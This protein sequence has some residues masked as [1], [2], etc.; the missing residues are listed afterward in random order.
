MVIGF[1]GTRRGMSEVQKEQVRDFLNTHSFTELHHGDCIGSDAEFHD[2]GLALVSNLY[3]H[4]PNSELH[5]RAYCNGPNCVIH[6]PKP[7]L[8]RNRA[9]VDAS[10]II[11]AAPYFDHE[12]VRSGV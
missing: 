11:I 4:P 3:I 6:S 7:H 8:E 10:D 1:T 2:I 9:I 5:L 12:V